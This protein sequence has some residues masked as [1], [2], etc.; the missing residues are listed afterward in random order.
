MA[1]DFQARKACA[2]TLTVLCGAGMVL[3]AEKVT[4]QTV[5]LKIST[6]IAEEA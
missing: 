3:S 4:K 6:G 5:M 1:L 2:V